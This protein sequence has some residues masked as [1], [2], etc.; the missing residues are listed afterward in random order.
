M[1]RVIRMIHPRD[2]YYLGNEFRSNYNMCIPEYHSKPR[3]K[4]IDGMHVG[5]KLMYE[6]VGT[7]QRFLTKRSP[8]LRAKI[9]G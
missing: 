3:E 8:S 7:H 2:T 6:H 9:T 1:T 5:V 4:G